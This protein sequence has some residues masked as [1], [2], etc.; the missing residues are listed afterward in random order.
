MTTSTS[1]AQA[2]LPAS[3]STST[4]ERKLDHLIAEV[5]A[6]RLELQKRK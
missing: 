4:L 2:P 1:T 5:Q 3:S 6:L